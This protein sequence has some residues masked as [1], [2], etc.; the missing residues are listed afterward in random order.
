M[1][2]AL[3]DMPLM[4]PPLL[5]RP[6]PAQLLLPAAMPV[7]AEQAAQEEQAAHPRQAAQEAQEG[8]AQQAAQF[9]P[10]ELP[11]TTPA[12]SRTSLIQLPL[13]LLLQELPVT[14]EQAA[15]AGQAEPAPAQ[16]LLPQQ[17]EPEAQ[18]EQAGLFI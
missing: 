10:E 2:E 16:G 13:S 6:L 11:A 15:Q 18:E 17:E 5:S 8:Q 7:T 4:K 12:G 14:A 3:S 1:P 9:T